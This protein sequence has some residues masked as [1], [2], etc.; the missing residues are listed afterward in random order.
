MDAPY[1]LEDMAA[2]A[3][4]LLDGLGLDSAHVVGGSL[5]G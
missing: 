2:D 1:S 4:G 5:A 3:V